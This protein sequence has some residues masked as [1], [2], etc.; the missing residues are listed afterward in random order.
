MPVKK[1]FN[2]LRY[3]YVELFLNSLNKTVGSITVEKW[4]AY[5]W[6]N[7]LYWLNKRQHITGLNI[8]YINSTHRRIN[9]RFNESNVIYPQYLFYLKRLAE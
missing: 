5:A 9:Y 8:E 1:K 3:V 4:K 2:L 7:I 6:R